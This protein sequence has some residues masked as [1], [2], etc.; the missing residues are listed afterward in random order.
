MIRIKI[1]GIRS[2]NDVGI[3]NE[4]LP[5]YIGFVFA[6]S[7]RRVSVEEA[8]ALSDALAAG[9]K[10]AGV[11]VNPDMDYVLEA[12][13]RA[14]L[15]V[16]QLHGDETP[17]M[18]SV[19]KKSLPKCVEVWKAIRVMDADTLQDMETFGADRYLL[20]SYTKGE[21]GGSG[22][23]FDWALAA[24][25]TDF[26]LAGG[27]NSGNVRQALETVRPFAVDVSSGVETDGFKDR[28]KVNEFIGIVRGWRENDE[29]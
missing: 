6:E 14:K 2:L 11:F 4:Y 26:I 7:R 18:V 29:R 5:D 13:E 17:E 19:L 24:E 22:V 23:C 21:R 16:V 20:D 25:G 15:D 28:D 1:C 12:V 27:L 9:I 3:M 8:A 10:K